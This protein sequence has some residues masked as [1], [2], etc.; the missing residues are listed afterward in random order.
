MAPFRHSLLLTLLLL[1]RPLVGQEPQSADRELLWPPQG[2][3]TPA[4]L[5]E[6]PYLPVPVPVKRADPAI[7]SLFG[8]ALA[9]SENNLKRDAAVSIVIVHERGYLDCS[10]MAAALTKVLQTDSDNRL[11][12]KD[13]AR[14]LVVIDAQAS[15]DELFAAIGRDADLVRVV[16]PALARWKHAAA[17]EAWLRRLKD[18]ETAPQHLTLSAIRG[19]GVARNP[20]SA[21]LLQQIILKSPRATYRAAAADALGHVQ[22][23]GLEPLA[24]QVL[25]EQS[26][27]LSPSSAPRRLLHQQMAGLLLRHHSSDAARK[28][29][30]T[31]AAEP[32]GAIAA[33]AWKSLLTSAPAELRT[34][35]EDSASASDPKVRGFV[36]QT[37][38]TTPDDS[39]VEQLGRLLNDRHPDVRNAARQALL[40]LSEMPELR[41]NVLTAGT[42]A[43]SSES[44]EGVEQSAVLLGT[45]DHEP[46]ADRCF[47]LLTHP[48]AEAAIAAAWALRK[49]A[50]PATLPRMLAFC[51][52][53]DAALAAKQGI[54]ASAPAVVGILFESM[55]TMDYEPAEGLLRQ[56]VPK[57]E[58][59]LLSPMRQSAIN[60]LGWLRAGSADEELCAMFYQ[61]IID[62]GPFP[63]YE[64][65]DVRYASAIAIG[66]IKATSFESKLRSQYPG[67]SNNSLAYAVEWALSQLTGEP[68]GKAVASVSG[69]PLLP[70]K[71]IGYRL[72]SPEAE[73]DS[74]GAATP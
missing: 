17:Q 63:I 22:Q 71:P 56:Y 43:L 47:E 20:S 49:L 12:R 28:I 42:A 61:R 50:I 38:R 26:A 24:E 40:V 6:D 16:E 58:P 52:G 48:R 37:L 33:V 67:Q 65:E 23:S 5:H 57:K 54:A 45:L 8:D 15:A 70:L 74:S 34:L 11:V 4:V 35:T 46:V 73:S 27:V 10:P 41:K 59:R 62:Q 39:A 68:L 30:L 3:L 36:V 14:A 21:G 18:F 2:T 44:W 72:E 1:T 9:S 31:L 19:L 66:R 13:V 55:G 32:N 53:I 7:L 29:L 51:E 64:L 69:P 25:G 60:A